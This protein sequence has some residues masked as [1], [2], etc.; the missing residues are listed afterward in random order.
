MAYRPEILLATAHASEKIQPT[1]MFN[2]QYLKHD[3]MG[4][5]WL[6]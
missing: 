4:H 2:Q 6:D 5:M 1:G 3:M